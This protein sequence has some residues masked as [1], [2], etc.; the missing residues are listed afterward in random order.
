MAELAATPQ[1]DVGVVSGRGLDDLNGAALYSGESVRFKC[2]GGQFL[3]SDGARLVGTGTGATAARFIVESATGP[4]VVHNG[5]G[6]RLRCVGVPAFAAV[7]ADAGKQDGFTRLVWQHLDGY[8]YR[9]A[10]RGGKRWL[11][12][13]ESGD[14]DRGP[15]PIGMSVGLVD[16]LPTCAALI[17]RIVAEARAIVHERL[18]SAV[19]A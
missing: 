11:E 8:A 17:G 5:E 6:V 9:Q 12:V 14:I 4:G 18:S 3:A 13:M 7:R 2:F 16:D 1:V 10:G 15:V 19:P